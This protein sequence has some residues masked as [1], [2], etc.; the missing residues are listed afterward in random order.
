MADERIVIEFKGDVKDLKAKLQD[1]NKEVSRLEKAANSVN[2]ALGVA[3]KGAAIGFGAL[4]AA[5]GAAINEAAK[6]EQI[7]TQFEVLTG[8][9]EQATKTVEQ[10]QNFAA[11]TPFQ[12]EGISDAAQQLLAFG[13][14]VDEITPK[15]Q[16]IG[17]VAAASG[18][19]IQELSQIYGQVAA[20]GKLTGERLLQLQE[21]AIP[22]GPAI[23]KTLGVAEESV[24]SLVSSGQVDLA[25]FEKAFASLSQEGEFAFEG[26]IKQSQTLT[27]L[28]STTKDNVSLLAA[29]IGKQLLPFAKEITTQFLKFVGSLRQSE[30]FM[31]GL[32]TVLSFV[33]KFGISTAEVFDTLGSRIGATLATVSAAIGAALNGDFAEAIEIFKSNDAAFREELLAKQEEYNQ[34]RK[35]IDAAL[36]EEEMALEEERNALTLEQKLLAKQA[37][38]EALAEQDRLAK[39]QEMER[40]LEHKSAIEKLEKTRLKTKMDVRRKNALEDRKAEIKEKNQFLQDE[41][42]FGQDTAKLRAFFRS[43]EHQAATMAI[44]A[45]ITLGQTGNKKLVAVAKAAAVA[46]AIMNTA[47][48]ITKALALGPILG[49]PLAAVLGAAGAVQIGVI[50]GVKFAKGGMFT[51][52]MAGIDS[53]PA[54]LQQGEVVAPTKNFEEVIGSVRAKREAERLTGVEGG[55]GGAMEV[56]V[57]FTDNAFEIIEEKILERRETG[58]GLL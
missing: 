24:R 5:A 48:G 16:K 7:T 52:G 14:E 49:P 19:P 12:F 28:F 3:A 4:A 51:G 2:S 1:S 35:A 47:E 55:L 17:D 58:V 32:K 36:F 15:L 25:T 18:T 56:V 6:F 37:Q 34:R 43:K 41:Q 10:L 33:A 45:L 9:A 22:I 23:A 20:A 50:S 54:T 27:G 38:D 42:R 30:Q 21:R 31:N 57:G 39:Q 26:M 29:S 53:I 11:T 46:K 13:F 8:S 44:D 40:E